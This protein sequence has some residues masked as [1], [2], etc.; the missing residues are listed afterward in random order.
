MKHASKIL[1]L[2][3]ATMIG[4]GG[5]QTIHTVIDA[6]GGVSN[7]VAVI[8]DNTSPD[9]G[10]TT[11]NSV[12]TTGS[13]ITIPG[14]FSR[15]AIAIAADGSLTVGAEGPNMTPMSMYTSKDGGK[16]WTG[17]VVAQASKQTAARCY[18]PDA[19]PGIISWRWGKKPYGVY[20]GPGYCIGGKVYYPQLTIGAARLARD[21]A[22][23][24][25]L[26][27]K[28]GDWGRIDAAGVMVERGKFPAGGTGE[29]FDFAIGP[30]GAWY[31]AMN[32][33]SGES[34]RF[35]YGTK[36]GGKTL[37][38][39]DYATY[40]EQGDDLCYPS[41]CVGTDGVYVATVYSGRL[42]LNIFR[43]GKLVYPPNKLADLGP[44]TMEIR[45][46]P[47]LVNTSKGV[48][49]VAKSGGNIV[50]SSV[51]A[52]LAGKPWGVIG[53]GA[54]PSVTSYGNTN[55]FVLAYSAGGGL[56]IQKITL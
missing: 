26:M 35:A 12:P 53:Q 38:W 10:E 25:Y 17:G 47:R 6:A 3:L 46:P 18:V 14:A 56:T 27:S 31:Q 11:S 29:K 37:A 36:T 15:S 49:I 41:I 7:I 8:T 33:S 51:A 39:A 21:P 54:Y 1:V 45:S 5:C 19:E 22:G 52:R 13:T 55:V 23:L 42:V 9:P 4:G 24:V 20:H 34:S 50:Y 48:Y 43:G 32:G 40:P 44:A 2:V 30:D 16:T 28:N